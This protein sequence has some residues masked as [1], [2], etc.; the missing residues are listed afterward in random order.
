MT[1]CFWR[2]VIVVENGPNEAIRRQ[3]GKCL[4]EDFT[5]KLQA[6]KKENDGDKMAC[7]RLLLQ[8]GAEFPSFG[9]IHICA[10]NVRK[11][12]CAKAHQNSE[13][14]NFF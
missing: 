7:L 4:R 11:K 9:W 14:G 1:L 13:Q 2:S 8:P 5:G 10:Y 3:E 12:K 6:E